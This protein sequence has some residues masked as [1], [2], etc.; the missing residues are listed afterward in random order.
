VLHGSNEFLIH[1]A[2]VGIRCDVF[3]EELR[4]VNTLILDGSVVEMDEILNSV[5][6]PPFMSNSRLVIVEGL[7]SRF[8]L[9]VKKLSTRS[10]NLGNWAGFVDRITEIPDT[11]NLVFRD[12]DLNSGNILLNK[13]GA[14]ADVQIFPQMRHAEVIEWIE[15][16]AR[17][18]G[19]KMEYGAK[20][21]LAEYVGSELRVLNS[22]L[23]KLSLY[24]GNDT[25]KREDIV[26]TVAYVREESIFM[27]VDAAVQGQVG[28][29]LKLVRSLIAS[30]YAPA[31]VIRMIERQVRLLI[32]AKHL[33]VNGIPRSTWPKKLSLS[34]YPLK[35]TLAQEVSFSHRELEE[36]HDRILAYELGVR[37][38]RVSE[39][40]GLEIL[41][42]E[43]GIKG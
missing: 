1:E 16:R 13:L 24:K 41:L 5:F 40:V 43:S 10:T 15:G 35:K 33:R 25:V 29:S 28:R 27:A 37:T 14:I 31:T 21:L 38:G 2:V 8:D 39:E 32:L 3:P 34:G 12:G 7:L 17:S 11:T 9:R 30:G 18:M 23:G 6:T 20:K 26:N 42:I 4:D 36:F 22:E 19:L